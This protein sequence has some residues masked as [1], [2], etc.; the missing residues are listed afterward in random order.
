MSALDFNKIIAFDDKSKHNLFDLKIN[1]LINKIDS[2]KNRF[3]F[4]NLIL[5]A[6]DKKK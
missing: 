4:K 3:V 2:K 6:Y 5:P 1:S